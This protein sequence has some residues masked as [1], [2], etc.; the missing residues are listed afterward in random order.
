MPRLAPPTRLGLLVRGP[1]PPTAALSC[2]PRPSLYPIAAPPLTAGRRCPGAKARQ[3][4]PSPGRR[5]SRCPT[6]ARRLTAAQ[7]HPIPPGRCLAPA[8]ATP[9]AM[10]RRGAREALLRAA[11]RP[12]ATA[13]LLP[14]PMMLRANTTRLRRRCRRC[15]LP[16]LLP[17]PLA[18]RRRLLLLRRPAGGWTASTPQSGTQ[19]STTSRRPLPQPLLLQNPLLPAPQPPCQLLGPRRDRRLQPQVWCKA[20]GCL[21]VFPLAAFDAPR[22]HSRRMLRTGGG[23]APPSAFRAL[24]GAA[25]P[26]APLLC[27]LPSLLMTADAAGQQRLPHY[28]PVSMQIP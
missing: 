1:R 3:A 22:P 11:P 10:W 26:C 16:T 25:K 17:A 14:L 19:R 7:R 9:R 4:L 23:A 2:P 12:R 28:Q 5:R 20:P 15:L 13:P 18:R 27:L 8:A 6:T 21:L 24:R